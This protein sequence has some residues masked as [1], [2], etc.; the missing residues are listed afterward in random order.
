LTGKTQ[1]RQKLFYL[2]SLTQPVKVLMKNFIYFGKAIKIFIVLVTILSIFGGYQLSQFFYRTNSDYMQR[3]IKML[4]M[5]RSLEDANIALSR[6]IQEWKDMLLRADDTE[7]YNKHQ[8]AF[9]HAALAL[10]EAF[11]HTKSAMQENGMETSLI[12]HM[13]NDNEALLSDYVAAK[14]FLKPQQIDSFRD[15]DK[16]ILG[17]DRNLQ[18]D[19]AALITEIREFSNQQLKQI[20]PIQWNRYLLGLLGAISLLVM[21]ILGFAF[22]RLFQDPDKKEAANPSAI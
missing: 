21:A 1:S 11:R 6:E 5:E 17:A 4:A 2:N 16:L 10:Q 19:S 20:I 22:A 8:Q 18:T 7:L 12:E 3:T 14:S 9:F 13:M 15:V